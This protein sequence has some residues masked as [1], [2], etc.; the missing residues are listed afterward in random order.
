MINLL[1]NAVSLAINVLI[2]YYSM[3]LL[4]LFNGGIVAKPLLY[5]SA[6][7]VA[8]AT[9]SLLSLLHRLLGLT[10]TQKLGPLLMMFGGL[11]AL[12]GLRKGYV[13]WRRLPSTTL[14]GSL[15]GP[16]PMTDPL[17]KEP[18]TSSSQLRGAVLHL[19]G[20]QLKQRADWEANN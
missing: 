2:I 7:A 18:G 20:F 4:K 9:G 5:I 6:G 15:K 14:A 11:F 13:Q 17:E 8:V 10:L 19:L 1:V 12:M 16:D 3:N